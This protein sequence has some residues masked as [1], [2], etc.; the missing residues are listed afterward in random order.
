MPFVFPSICANNK[1]FTDNNDNDD[2][3][4]YSQK[5]V[6]IRQKLGT[7]EASLKEANVM[8]RK[9]NVTAEQVSWKIEK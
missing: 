5:I 2:G 7:M 1:K 6:E 4:D 8:R 9:M 3:S